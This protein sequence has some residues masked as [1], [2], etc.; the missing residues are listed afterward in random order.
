[1][2]KSKDKIVCAHCLYEHKPSEIIQQ[3]VPLNYIFD[4]TCDSPRLISMLKCFDCNKE[5]NVKINI[6]FTTEK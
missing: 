3:I 2:I 4:C 6:E 1:M 5:N